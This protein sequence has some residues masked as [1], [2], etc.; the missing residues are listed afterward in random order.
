MVLSQYRESCPTDLHESHFFY[1]Y[2]LS[3]QSIDW[4]PYHGFPFGNPGKYNKDIK[5][6]ASVVLTTNMPFSIPSHSHVLFK[7][8]YLGLVYIQQIQHEANSHKQQTA[9]FSPHLFH[10]LSPLSFVTNYY[11]EIWI[12]VG[13][14]GAYSSTSL[15]LPSTG[16]VVYSKV[17]TYVDSFFR[18]K[19][20]RLIYDTSYELVR[21]DIHLNWRWLWV[22]YF[23]LFNGGGG[24]WGL[25]GRWGCMVVNFVLNLLF[26]QRIMIHI[27]YFVIQNLFS[28]NFPKTWKFLHYVPC[29]L[30]FPI[31]SMIPNFCSNWG[32]HPTNN[33]NRKTTKIFPFLT[34]HLE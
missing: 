34:L 1:I 17:T 5:D 33:W 28:W 20:K 27:P 8:E 30:L 32:P 31:I 3:R 15:A 4:C 29:V 7:A 19:D 26:L 14:E 22:Q 24:V 18:T 10:F 11:G 16:H 12:Y 9:F 2:F 6:I 13:E 21:S 25:W 23:F